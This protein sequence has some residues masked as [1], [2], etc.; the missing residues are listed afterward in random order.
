MSRL[1]Q[2]RRSLF[3]EM[4]DYASIY[5]PLN[6]DEIWWRN[7][8]RCNAVTLFDKLEHYENSNVSFND[9]ILSFFDVKKLPIVSPTLYDYYKW[10]STTYLI[11]QDITIPPY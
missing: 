6:E 11:K 3:R 8:A 2:F 4:T 5:Q 9:I 10:C 7:L 1:S